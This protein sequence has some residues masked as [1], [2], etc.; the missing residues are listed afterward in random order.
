MDT[1]K[2]NFASLPMEEKMVFLKE[3]R[4]PE[5]REEIIAKNLVNVKILIA[6]SVNNDTFIIQSINTIE[7]LDRIC[8]TLAKRVR[9]WYGYYFP[10]LSYSIEDNEIFI[11]RI[12]QKSKK[13]FM[14]EL[15]LNVSMGPELLE[16]DLDAIMSF[17][18]QVN[19]MYL[20]GDNIIKYLEDVMKEYTPNIYAVTGALIGA[21]LLDKARSLKH[22]SQMPSS[23]VQLLGAEQALF[24]HLRNK[25]IRPP[26]HGFILSHPLVMNASREQK[27]SMA[28]VLAAKIS[29]AS[30][31]DY[32]KGEFLGD[33]LLEE[34]EKHSRRK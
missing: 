16:K 30:K 28:R 17:V 22:L 21:K 10:E 14:Q 18:R 27:G 29:I 19:D 23:T 20:E 12:I 13:E 24:R 2:D 32:F 25:R 7:E 33:K 11:K 5:Y 34:V 9:E 31:I 3:Q 15:E 4:K 1:N 6:G 8:N 26:K